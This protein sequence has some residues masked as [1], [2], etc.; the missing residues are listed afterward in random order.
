MRHTVFVTGGTGYIGS[1][2]IPALG[3]RGH[4]VQALVRRGSEPKLPANCTAI[5]GDALDAST[6]VRRIAPADVF[7]HLVGV[8][9]PSPAKAEEFKHID[10]VS[11]QEAVRAAMENNIAHFVYLSVAHPAPVMKEYI[12]VRMEGERLIRESGMSATFVRPWYVLGP[13]HRWAYT[14]KPFYWL[15]ERVP[16]L[17]EQA[18]RLGLVTLDQLVSALVIAVEHPPLQIRVI[19]VPGIQT[20]ARDTSSLAMEA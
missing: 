14:L 16:S 15:A 3:A 17:R 7:V 10:L 9:H 1:R 8:A 19:D 5:V 4:A 6:F 2:L 12:A 18:L 11:V 13:G 20:L